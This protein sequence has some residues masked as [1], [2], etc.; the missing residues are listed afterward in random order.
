MTLSLSFSLSL[1]KRIK[2]KTCLAAIF[3]YLVYL[4]DPCS[5]F[6]QFTSFVAWKS[7]SYSHWHFY[8]SSAFFFCGKP[9]SV[10]PVFLPAFLPLLTERPT[11]AADP[12]SKRNKK[13]KRKKNNEKVKE[14]KASGTIRRSQQL[15]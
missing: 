11:I 1:S 10:P 2:L 15:H 5:V 4:L 6:L 9:D 12:K 8:V 3:F 14:R 7:W 13:E